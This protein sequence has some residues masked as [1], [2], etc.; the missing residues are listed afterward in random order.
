MEKKAG[1]DG[2]KG[3]MYRAIGESR[4]VVEA[5]PYIYSVFI[6]FKSL[7]GDVREKALDLL[8]KG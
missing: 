1:P 3:E 6:H 8:V 5:I 2:L 4:E 7:D